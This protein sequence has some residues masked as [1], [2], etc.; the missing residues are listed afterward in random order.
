MAISP[1]HSSHQLLEVKGIFLMRKLGAAALQAVEE[2]QMRLSL[3][4][5]KAAPAAAV[6]V[7]EL[8]GEPENRRQASA[9]TIRNPRSVLVDWGIRKPASKGRVL[10][11]DP[12]I[13]TYQFEM[14]MQRKKTLRQMCAQTHTHTQLKRW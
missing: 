3:S 11:Q 8:P 9:V 7:S 5:Q 13:C 4:F 6:L 1:L 12:R 14:E 10:L 2:R